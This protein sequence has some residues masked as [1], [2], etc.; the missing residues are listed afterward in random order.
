MSAYFVTGA[1]TEV[2]KT[3]VSAALLT[4]ARAR[5]VTVQGLKPVMSGF[6]PDNLQESDAGLLLSACGE[7]TSRENIDRICLYA[8]QAPR[9]PNIA[10]REE[11]VSMDGD[12]ITSF[13]R[14]H[15]ATTEPRGLLLIEGAGGVMSPTTDAMLQLDLICA[16]SLPTILVTGAYLGAIS[17]TL[18]ALKILQAT[19]IPVA[20]I[21][22]SQ[23]ESTGGDPAGIADELARLQKVCVISAP[24]GQSSRVLGGAL[25]DR[26]KFS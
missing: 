17:H 18:S 11:C 16:L 26:L 6:A 20:A 24:Y 8:F 5:G 15:I 10:A 21:V 22:V 25:L 23:S 19:E 2:G 7:T 9:A 14:R 4:E 12:E 13:C 1:G 3:F